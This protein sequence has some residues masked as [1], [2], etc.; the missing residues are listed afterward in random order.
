MANSETLCFHLVLIQASGSLLHKI[1]G[2]DFRIQPLVIKQ[3]SSKNGVDQ[4]E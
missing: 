4:N 3:N 2:T 1:L